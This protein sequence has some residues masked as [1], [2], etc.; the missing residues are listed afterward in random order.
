[1]AKESDQLRLRIVE[2]LER[3]YES[4]TIVTELRD[5][6][7][8]T[9][10]DWEAV[11]APILDQLDITQAPVIVIAALNAALELP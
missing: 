1:M 10:G 8:A 3:A 7:V 2:L 11:V 6:I 4:A 9:H 5:D